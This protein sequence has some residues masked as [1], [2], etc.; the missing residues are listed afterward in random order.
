MPGKGLRF[1]TGLSQ[2]NVGSD[3][4]DMSYAWSKSRISQACSGESAGT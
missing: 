1:Q 4:A 2:A 3:A